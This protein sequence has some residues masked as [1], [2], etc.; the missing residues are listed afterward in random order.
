MKKLI[1]IIICFCLF[2]V[3]VEA[4]KIVVEAE[5]YSSITP[6][7]VK[8]VETSGSISNNGFIQI[9]LRR[10]HATTQTGPG[11]SG[12]CTYKINVTQAGNYSFW[13]RAWWY[14]SCG[15]SF[16][17]IIDNK[18]A[19]YVEDATYQVWHWVKGPTTALSVGIHT[20]KIQNREDGARLDQF[21]LN[22]NSNYVP[23]R[24][25]VATQ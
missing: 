15:N 18:P 16:F 13:F 9:P 25:E 8:T 7:M 3:S 2:S 10:P 19:M 12:S 4:A 17:V 14:D 21:L 1:A 23:T 5:K 6:S 22:S 24:V 20:I 11:D